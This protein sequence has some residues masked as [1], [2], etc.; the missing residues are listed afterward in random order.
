MQH[1]RRA[2]ETSLT[3]RGDSNR[4]PGRRAPR[5]EV[6]QDGVDVGMP[7]PAQA[8]PGGALAPT[9]AAPHSTPFTR[10]S[11]SSVDPGTSRPEDRSPAPASAVSMLTSLR[12]SVRHQLGSGGSESEAA[13]KGSAL[14]SPVHK[15]KTRP[16]HGRW[17]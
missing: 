8:E 4:H 7:A 9:P 15:L 6:S 3:P 1:T 11:R 16:G 12:C 17:P 13:K 5:A 14:G 10:K 2:R